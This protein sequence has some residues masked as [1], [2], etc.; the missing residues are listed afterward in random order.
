MLYFENKEY[1]YDMAEVK[2]LDI[3]KSQLEVY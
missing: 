1:K 3:W 2:E